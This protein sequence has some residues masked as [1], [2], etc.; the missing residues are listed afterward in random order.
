MASHHSFEEIKNTLAM[1][2]GYIADDQTSCLNVDDE[3][4][5]DAI[6]QERLTRLFASYADARLAA[7]RNDH[8]MLK[9]ALMQAKMRTMSLTTFFTALEDDCIALLSYCDADADAM[10]AGQDA[11]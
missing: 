10:P 4:N 8:R 1:I 7:Q 5:V 11:G 9:A 6:Y 2:S 3:Q